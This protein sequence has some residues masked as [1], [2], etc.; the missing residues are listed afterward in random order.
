MLDRRS[1]LA[2]PAFLAFPSA[3][4]AAAPAA[5]PAPRPQVR[6]DPGRLPTLHAGSVGALE[7][8]LARLRATA[9]AGGWPQIAPGP[10]LRIGQRGERVSAL[11]NRLVAGGQLPPGRAGT[12]FDAAMLDAVRRAQVAHGITDTGNCGPETLNAL[13]VPVESRIA[14][15][16]RSLA[17][18][19]RLKAPE[20]GRYV[21]ANVAAAAV[22]TV[23]DGVVTGR[24]V[25]VVGRDDRPTPELATRIISVSLNPFWSVPRSIAGDLVKKAGGNA[26]ALA[27]RGFRLLVGERPAELSDETLK[28]AL[29]GAGYLR[30]DPGPGNALGPVRLDFGPRRGAYFMHGTAD[31]RLFSRRGARAFSSGC[32]RVENVTSLAA[33]VLDGAPGDWTAS[34]IEEA[35]RVAD[36]AAASRKVA[37]VAPVPVIWTYLT[38]FVTSDG[39]LHFRPDVY[40]RD[41]S[42]AEP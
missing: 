36:P 25:A 14:A 18:L 11:A 22:E 3:A 29:R 23:R 32:I 7:E 31:T 40:E 13:N 20:S 16:E 6:L 42:A 37:P 17:R 27:R 38:A 39:T 12:V 26:E 33:F 15:A 1:F 5:A 41:G 9:L 4:I 24:H 21:L 35:I 30:Q 19:R 28:L 2:F 10:T 34:R 8:A